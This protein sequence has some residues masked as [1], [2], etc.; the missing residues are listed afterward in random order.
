[1]KLQEEQAL[2]RFVQRQEQLC[3]SEGWH[4]IVA[5]D[6]N[7]FPDSALDRWSIEPAVARP[8]SIAMQLADMD[9]RDC[10]QER[11]PSVRAYTY[12]S[13]QGS[14]SRLDQIWAMPP[15]GAF[16]SILNAAILW[17]W[18]HRLDHDP[19]IA[20]FL[21]HL[22]GAAE[23]REAS[24]ALPW[25]RLITS[26]ADPAELLKLKGQVEASMEPLRDDLEAACA[27]LGQI[28]ESTGQL[29]A[30]CRGL[31][32]W[33][34]KDV[35]DV[36]RVRRELD[37]LAD[38]VEGSMLSAVPFPRN[39]EGCEAIRRLCARLHSLVRVLRS[40]KVAIKQ[41]SLEIP[42]LLGQAQDSWCQA[43]R[44]ATRHSERRDGLVRLRGPPSQGA[45]PFSDDPAGWA[46][47]LGFPAEVA[48]SWASACPSRGIGGCDDSVIDRV[49]EV[50][51]CASTLGAPSEAEVATWIGCAQQLLK[52]AVRRSSHDFFWSRVRA[53]RAG[54]VGAW[55]RMMR[56][57]K[58][59]VLGYAPTWL[60]LPDGS[61]AR[62]SCAA[63]VRLAAAQE[64]SQL[65]CEPVASWTHPLVRRWSDSLRHL[66]APW[67][68]QWWHNRQG[69]SGGCSMRL[70]ALAR[71]ESNMFAGRAQRF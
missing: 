44:K 17:G 58:G 19:M 21:C 45:V 27:R 37:A 10:F 65:L 7:S 60:Q 22:P 8:Q 15:R 54:N 39:P 31:A 47:R 63:E 49:P 69:C 29:Q 68:C 48:H 23:L 62:P 43:R 36:S 13:G 66:G 55:S 33:Q 3:E 34:S 57:S 24:Q 14:A 4:L 20:D 28:N 51:A 64:W 9:L 30:V 42:G 12:Y 26:M 16:L 5:G 25:R 1:M 46:A 52:A 53:L 18:L 56:G 32:P 6:M 11:H 59:S 67:T 70:L 2:I 38:S 40:L 41:G 71:S 35:P 50:L 61:R